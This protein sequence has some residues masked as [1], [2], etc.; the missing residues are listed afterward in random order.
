MKT[1]LLGAVA[2]AMITVMKASPEAVRRVTEDGKK[3]VVVP[4]V[5]MTEGVRRAANSQF[6]E[7]VPAEEIEASV[8]LWEGEPVTLDHPKVKDGDEVQYVSAHSVEGKQFIIGEFRNASASDGKLKL[9]AWIDEAEV[10][11]LSTHED[12]NIAEE[13]SQLIARIDAGHEIE[14]SG[15]Y[16]VTVDRVLGEHD[17]VRYAGEQ[18]GIMP[19]HGAILRSDQKGACS[20]QD[21]CGAPRL[22]AAAR[23]R[24]SAFRATAEHEGHAHNYDEK[25]AGRTAAAKGHSHTY[26]PGD[27][28]TGRA[29]GHAHEMPEK[30]VTRAEARRP[31]FKGLE[32]SPWGQVDRSFAAYAKA[33]LK[34]SGSARTT[35]PSSVGDAPAEMRQWIAAHTLLGSADATSVRDLLF[36]PVV[37]PENARLN[38]GALKA[39]LAGKGSVA[40]LSA[41]TRTS[42]EEAARKLL[43]VQFGAALP[44]GG[45]ACSLFEVNEVSQGALWT[46][47]QIALENQMEENSNEYWYL[48]V[49]DAFSDRVIYQQGS[50]LMQQGFTATV[51]GTVTLDGAPVRVRPVPDYIAVNEAADLRDRETGDK[52]TTS[53]KQP[54]TEATMETVTDKTKTPATT[55]VKPTPVTE[56]VK[57]PVAAAAKPTFTEVLASAD[58]ATRESIEYGQRLFKERRTNLIDG[59]VKAAPAVYTKE[60]L[61]GKSFDDLSELARFAQAVIPA[62]ATDQPNFAGLGLPRLSETDDDAAPTP[63]TAFKVGSRPDLLRKGAQ[64]AAETK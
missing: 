5:L 31:A 30:A 10:A 40:S 47:L 17:G 21:G 56:I 49:V 45:C 39:V 2:R 50:D 36:Y 13:A 28:K 46:S 3:Y 14:V 1:R 51:D 32:T 23:E 29:N 12:S 33:Y 63:K 8:P 55:E 18:H 41:M 60:K 11:R 16:F 53:E 38:E 37:N 59:L 15:G 52:S 20:W 27:A 7:F 35:V 24:I 58:P 9:E 26:K 6:P 43:N 22:S 54:T 19:D 62:V 25:S 42:A 4:I 61:E 34:A 48:Y 57:E 64:P 44:E